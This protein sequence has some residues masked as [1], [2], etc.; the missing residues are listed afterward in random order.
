MDKSKFIRDQREFVLCAI[1]RIQSSFKP[2]YTPPDLAYSNNLL[3]SLNENIYN[4][5]VTPEELVSLMSYFLPVCK[6]ISMRVCFFR[7]V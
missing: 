7:C 1:Q 2:E 6:L 4:I 5:G 3:E